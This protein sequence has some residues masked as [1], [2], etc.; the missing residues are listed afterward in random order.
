MVG[1]ITIRK[2]GAYFIEGLHTSY[3]AG[4]QG[5]G[6]FL[7]DFEHGRKNNP[8]HLLM[9]HTFLYERS[10]IIIDMQLSHCL[11]IVNILITRITLQ[12]IIN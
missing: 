12:I 6:L 11:I 7:S 8:Y 2:E 5:L 3:G 1:A 9:F 4:R 10:L